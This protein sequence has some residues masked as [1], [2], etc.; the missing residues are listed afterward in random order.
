MKAQAHSLRPA[1][2]CIVRRMKAVRSRFR[3]SGAGREYLTQLRKV[4]FS[5]VKSSPRLYGF[6]FL[7]L[8]SSQCSKTEQAEIGTSELFRRAP[9]FKGGFL[10]LV[11]QGLNVSINGGLLTGSRKACRYLNSGSSKPDSNPRPSIGTESGVIKIIQE[12][13]HA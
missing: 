2:S 11:W 3:K 9:A 10:L 8:Q 13:Y 4:W 6:Y 7:G 5:I 1:L 12:A